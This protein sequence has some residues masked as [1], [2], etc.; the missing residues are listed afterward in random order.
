MSGVGELSGSI[1]VKASNSETDKEVKRLKAELLKIPNVAVKSVLR[2]VF[3]ITVR[4]TVQDSGKA[5]YN[6]WIGTGK[7]RRR[8]YIDD[9]NLGPIGLPGEKRS[10]GGLENR[11]ANASVVSPDLVVNLKISYM[12]K[13]LAT[14]DFTM[15]ATM[16]NQTPV[17]N[18][19]SF[20]GTYEGN[21]KI[22]VAMSKAMVE[23]QGAVD[24][25]LKDI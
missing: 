2:T 22:R 21:A 18:S 9:Y 5:A 4:E 20:R 11:P 24:R 7:A 17:K 6:W 1:G 19:E 25:A 12:Q 3:P 8:F 15:G 13:I 16:Y 23:A 14:Q 10:K